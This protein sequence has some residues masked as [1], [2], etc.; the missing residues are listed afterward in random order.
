M[1]KKTKKLLPEVGV[2]RDKSLLTITVVK[3]KHVEQ[4]ELISM[5]ILDEG[6]P[7][8]AIGWYVERSKD[9]PTS[10]D[11]VVIRTGD[12]FFRCDVYMLANAKA[13]ESYP[14]LYEPKNIESPT[15]RDNRYREQKE[16]VERE[17]KRIKH[18]LTQLFVE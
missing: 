17:V 8:E 3:K 10:F 1:E 11:Y 15:E 14:D 18:K 5:S 2:A 9:S 7:G 13:V 4:M 6:M 16:V 12:K